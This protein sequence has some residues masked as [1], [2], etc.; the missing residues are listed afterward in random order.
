M[1]FHEF[2]RLKN[3]DAIIIAVAHKEYFS[4]LKEE[5]DKHYAPGRKVLIDIKGLLNKEEYSGY[6][7]YYWRL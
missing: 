2:G 4:L 6:E 7:Y 3:V 5:I 1:E